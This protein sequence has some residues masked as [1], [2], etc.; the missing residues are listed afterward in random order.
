MHRGSAPHGSVRRTRASRPSTMNLTG[1]VALT[2]AV[3]SDALLAS[4]HIEQRGRSNNRSVIPRHMGSVPLAT[5]SFTS[6]DYTASIII[7]SRG[8]VLQPACQFVCLRSSAGDSPVAHASQS[9]LWVGSQRPALPHRILNHPISPVIRLAILSGINAQAV[10]DVKKTAIHTQR[11]L[12]IVEFTT[13]RHSKCPIT[14]SSARFGSARPYSR[15]AG[16]KW[17]RGDV[18]CDHRTKERMG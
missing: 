16:V 7:T 3:T 12:A 9:K 13:I 5:T 8:N 1:P 17:R 15:L 6:P 2:S 14:S 4:T 10:C 18:P 11:T